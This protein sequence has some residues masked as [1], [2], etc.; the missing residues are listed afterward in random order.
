MTLGPRNTGRTT[1]VSKSPDLLH[2]W[3]DSVPTCKHTDRPRKSSYHAM[4]EWRS[5]PKAVRP[6]VRYGINRQRQ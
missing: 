2:R 4:M 1:H 3:L 6:L 5:L